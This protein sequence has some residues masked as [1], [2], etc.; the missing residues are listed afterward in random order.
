MV[1]SFF[2]FL[3]EPDL[4]STVVTACKAFQGQNAWRCLCCHAGII[5]DFHVNRPPPLPLTIVISSV[6]YRLSPRSLSR[7]SRFVIRTAYTSRISSSVNRSYAY[8]TRTPAANMPTTLKDF[9]SVFPRLVEDLSQQCQQYG[10]P[11][12][13]LE[14][15]QKVDSC[16]SPRS[17]N[18]NTH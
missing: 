13:A 5:V 15:Y 17:Q 12:N 11:K 10:L 18:A 8:S 1:S 7:L 9:E 14:W 3:A 6:I 2:L 4:R 16:T